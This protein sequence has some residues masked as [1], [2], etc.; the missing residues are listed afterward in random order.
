MAKLSVRLRNKKRMQMAANQLERRKEYR[1]QRLDFTL[2][3]EERM[4]AQKKLQKLA[5][6]GSATR[7]V[8]RCQITG[9]G[10]AVYSLFGLSRIKFRELAL[11]GRIPGVT[12]A[13]W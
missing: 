7:V 1:Q 12:K 5:R 13:S 10:R 6:N 11:I 4:A 9:R 8:S 3:D 2:S